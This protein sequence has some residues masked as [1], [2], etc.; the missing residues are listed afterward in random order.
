MS[1][2]DIIFLLDSDDFFKKN[3][4]QKIV[5]HFLNNKTKKIVFDFPIIKKRTKE[6]FVENKINLFKTYWGYIHPTSC[7]SFRRGYLKKLLKRISN[8]K[9]TDIWMDLRILLYSKYENE[10]NIVN[11]NLTSTDNLMEMSHL[12]FQNLV[13]LGGKEESKHMSIF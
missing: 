2:G 13:N 3:K 1:K 4:V 8:D 12:N 7:I 10:Y 9:F 5:N 11:E 6:K